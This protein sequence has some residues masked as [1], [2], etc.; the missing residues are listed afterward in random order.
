MATLSIVEEL[1]TILHSLGDPKDRAIASRRVL[2]LQDWTTLD[3]LGHDLGFSKER[4]RQREVEIKRRINDRRRTLSG[5]LSAEVSQY[6]A[7]AENSLP[8]DD[9]W[10]F[11]PGFLMDADTRQPSTLG[12]LFLYLAGPYEIWHDLLLPAGARTRVEN[13]S[14]KLWNSLREG[15]ALTIEEADQSAHRFGITSPD[16]VNQVLE[17]I[18]SK[19]PHVYAMSGAKYVYLPKAADRAV[20]ELE[21]QGTPLPLDDLAQRCLVSE[22]T[23]LNAIGDDDRLTRLNRNKYGL[24]E[25][26]FYEYDGIMGAIHKALDELGDT[27]PVDDVAEWVT[28]RFDVEWGS[29]IS[30]ATRH[31]A[32]VTSNGRVRRRRRD[33]EPTWSGSRQLGEVG[34]CLDIDGLPVLRV[35][36][37]ANLWRGS[38]KPVP[39]LWADR[40]GL[41]PGQ[42]MD[43]GTGQDCVA[44]SWAGREPALGSLRT[45]ALKN[46]WP[47]EGIG[48]LI[49]DG[50]DL[51]ST[52][53]PLPPEP[54][55]DAFKAALAMDSLFALPK[56]SEA[57]PLGGAFW[58][59]LG[60]RLGLQPLYRVPGMILA[61]LEAR[62]EKVLDLYVEALRRALLISE[63]RGLVIQIDM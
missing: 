6:A 7:H 8:I 58:V 16:V 9:A 20:Q 43:I 2:A 47:Q 25:W 37:D 55:E 38:G 35:M 52:W 33:E 24:A 27:A 26:G 23:L 63:A 14:R 45:F 51:K 15:H 30:Y 49:L 34:D 3:T 44:L 56:L 12:K 62:R 4:V 48:F 60:A 57:H 32:F 53:R 10:Q 41:T 36:I 59:A 17:R 29:V 61:R 42:K 28:K 21:R 1:D 54:S 46:G 50:T 39:R 5:A 40:V 19:H 18:Q 31:H 11:L 22:G 13:L